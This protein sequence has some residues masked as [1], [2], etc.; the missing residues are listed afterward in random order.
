MF[1]VSESDIL[2]QSD[3]IHSR[4][5][6]QPSDMDMSFVLAVGDNPLL[7]E[8]NISASQLTQTGNR[9]FSATTVNFRC[10]ERSRGGLF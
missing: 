2:C 7:V 6:N 1:A 9:L 3:S 5:T 4:N 10:F 8:I